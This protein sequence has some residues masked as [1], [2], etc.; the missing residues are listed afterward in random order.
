MSSERT[1]QRPSMG[2]LKRQQPA[3]FAAQD[4]SPVVERRRSSDAARADGNDTGKSDQRDAHAAHENGQRRGGA[5]GNSQSVHTKRTQPQIASIKATNSL[6][7]RSLDHSDSLEQQDESDNDQ[8]DDS[9][10]RSADDRQATSLKRH[11]QHTLEE[12][13]RKMQAELLALN[14][15]FAKEDML[16][17][18]SN[19]VAIFNR[20]DQLK[21]SQDQLTQHFW[22]LEDTIAA[23]RM[24]ASD[25]GATDDTPLSNFGAFTDAI[26]MHKKGVFESLQELSNQLDSLA[27]LPSD[28][29]A[30][31]EQHHPLHQF[32]SMVSHSQDD[33]TFMDMFTRP[34]RHYHVTANTAAATTATTATGRSNRRRQ[35]QQ[36]RRRNNY[37]RDVAVPTTLRELEMRVADGNEFAE[38]GSSDGSGG[39]GGGDGDHG[40]GMEVSGRGWGNE[41]DGEDLDRLRQLRNERTRQLQQRQQRQ[42]RQVAVTD[43]AAPRTRARTQR[44]GTAQYQQ[45]PSPRAQRRQQQQ[46]QQQQ[47][48]RQPERRRTGAGPYTRAPREERKDMPYPNANGL[49]YDAGD[50]YEQGERLPFVPQPQQRQQQHRPEPQRDSA[51]Y[52]GVVDSRG[53]DRDDDR[54][55]RGGVVRRARRLPQEGLREGRGGARLP[56]AGRDGVDVVSSEVDALLADFGASRRWRARGFGADASQSSTPVRS[57]GGVGGGAGHGASWRDRARAHAQRIS[58]DAGDDDHD[59]DD[60][61]DGEQGLG[62]WQIRPAPAGDDA[63][64]AVRLRRAHGNGTAVPARTAAP[65]RAPLP[66]ARASGIRGVRESIGTGRNTVFVSDDGGLDDDDYDDAGHGGVGGGGGLHRARM[67]TVGEEGEEGDGNDDSLNDSIAFSSDAHSSRLDN[68][69]SGLSHLGDAGGYDN[70]GPAEDSA[71][72]GPYA[73]VGDGGGGVDGD[74]SGRVAHGRRV[75]RDDGAADAYH[76]DDG[77]GED[78]NGGGERGRP[79]AG[80]R[81]TA[82]ARAARNVPA[83]TAATASRRKSSFFFDGHHNDDDNE[84]DV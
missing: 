21:R 34:S 76:G 44:D 9:M 18:G 72:A 79:R 15:G 43:A 69:T 52:P 6:P 32:S 1:T 27:P 83:S 29:Q 58:S 37:S 78:G 2:D 35:Q 33:S 63:V 68:N 17:F 65:R 42:Q 12:Q 7:T 31:S 47:Q 5:V 64:N 59:D 24:A 3:I 80:R 50:A 23:N 74:S 40:G 22:N 38:E 20:F 56:S 73:A 49:D 11:E 67:S 71:Y 16:A 14:R 61:G 60:D 4:G 82:R 39:G 45:R 30:G 54:D 8:L 51:G 26:N 84:V 81:S 53:N 10:N 55:D 57:A 28:T 48:E 75:R 36:Q 41:G 25:N 13:A 62:S 19:T 77:D 70:D 66:S 46:Q